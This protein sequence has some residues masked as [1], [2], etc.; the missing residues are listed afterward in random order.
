MTKEII[1]PG[2]DDYMTPFF[3]HFHRVEGRELARCYVVGLMMEGERKSVEPMSEK[4][5]APERSMQRLLTEV[6]WDEEEIIQEYRQGMLA[7]TSDPQGV[8]VVDDTAFPKKG[9]ESVC[10]ARQYCG[11]TGKVDNCQ[12]GVSL[13]YVGQDVAWPYVMNLF[14]PKSWDDPDDAQ[15]ALKR[16]K[17]RMPDTARYKEKWRMALEQIDLASANGVPHRAVV[18]DSWYGNI[19][20][21]RRGLV[22][23]GKCYVVGV[24]SNT[25][26]FLETPVIEF[27]PP[28]EKKRGRPR[29]RPQ[30]VK[31]SPEP[32][33]VSELGEKVEE[34]AWEHL[35]LRRDS[36][37]KP[38][39]VE[40]VSLRVWP[41]IG[42]QKGNIHEDVWLI[43]ERRKRERGG[44]EL[45]Y[46]FSN[47]PQGQ[48]TIEMV[49][50]YQERYWIEQ[51]YQ[52]LKEELGLDHHEGRS[53]IGWHRHVLLVFM[54]YGYLTHLR[55]L[56]KKQ[57]S[58]NSRK[59]W[60]RERKTVGRDSFF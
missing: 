7:E 46:F 54:A 53:W 6:K 49:R 26:V 47:M 43:I 3:A 2:I 60:L 4:V 58:R 16:Q 15:C 11:A 45:R 28:K 8:L 55:L 5:N 40:A 18:T 27:A 31:V 9:T 56:E 51:G 25:E 39:V 10:V 22:D 20:E 38:L 33:K 59:T 13:M 48:P 29:K 19:P 14:V 37:G 12:V 24:Y 17:T 50:L 1:F 30:V 44:F 34:D 32:V 57:K 36:K 21:F 41:A 42:Y 52:Q 35:E 23:R